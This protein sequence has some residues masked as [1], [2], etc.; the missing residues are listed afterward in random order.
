VNPDALRA[1][2]CADGHWL[3]LR[4]S[5][6]DEIVGRAEVLPVGDALSLLAGEGVAAAQV[7]DGATINASA[8]F[9]ARGDVR[10]VHDPVIGRVSVPGE[11]PKAWA[12]P[13]LPLFRPTRPDA[14]RG[15]VL[16]S[17]Q[18]SS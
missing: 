3:M 16:G 9:K 10:E 1:V 18:G 13:E 2:R 7:H 15:R 5:A 11:I 4:A 14:D 17:G 8:Y 12:E 6:P